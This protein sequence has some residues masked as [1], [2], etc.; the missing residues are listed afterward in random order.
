MPYCKKCG[1]EIP[2]DATYC[3]ECGSPVQ[4][5]GERQYRRAPSIGWDIG[6]ILALFIGFVIV[7]TSFGLIV[8][9][10][11]IMWANSRF[12]DAEGFLMSHEA[13]FSVDSYALVQ[14]G[15]N[16][17]IDVSLPSSFWIPDPGDWVTVRLVAKSNDPSQEVFLG[18]ASEAD[19]SSYL[20]DVMFDEIT[21]FSWSYNPFRESQPD[22][23]YS[24]S[25]GSAPSG[26]P[27]IHSFWE[28]QTSGSGTQTLEWEPATGRYWIVAMNADGSAGVDI[29][30][31]LGARLP[32]LSS[33]G[34]GLMVG[35]L[36]LL[37]VGGIIFWRGL[38][39][40]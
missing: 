38:F 6:R 33:V 26:P 19:A 12:T 39:P 9:G 35:G 14:R 5:P 27:I 16:V 28:V 1:K 23:S 36:V 17:N 10:G 13:D 30:A 40:R 25:P 3:P 18:I 24:T 20:D 29:E 4:A 8:G 34:V 21:H 2:E 22:V 32:V 37:F 7:A 15:V 11:T 31:Q